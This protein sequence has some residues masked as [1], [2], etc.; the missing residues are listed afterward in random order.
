[1]HKTYIITF[2]APGIDISILNRIMLESETIDAFWN[3]IPLVYCVKSLNTA[4][5]LRGYFAQHFGGANYMIAELN[6]HNIDGW[7]PQEAW[8]WFY[9]DVEEQKRDK[10]RL[11]AQHEKNRVRSLSDMF[12]LGGPP[13]G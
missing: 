2:Y 6:P 3:Y 11:L 9:R 7:L 5:A 8:A 1:M 4:A 13:D 10:A 12:G